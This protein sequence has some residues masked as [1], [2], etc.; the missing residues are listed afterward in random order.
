MDAKE[1]Y[2]LITRNLQEIVGHD[3][4][5]QILEERDL[6]VYWGTATTG[7]PHIGYFVPIVKI[8]DFLKAGCSVKLLFADLHA[9]LDNQKAP[10][11]LLEHRT[12]YYKF[13]IKEMLMSIGVPIEKLKFVKGTDHQLGNEYSLDMY[14]LATLASLR[15]TKKA[16][17]EVVKQLENPKM[18]PLLYPIL[19]ALD[20]QY[21]GVDAQFGGVDQ[22]KIFM[23]AREFLPKIEYPKR[24]HLMNPMMPGLTGEKMSSSVE[25]TKIDLLD[26]EKTV[27]KKI[28]KAFCPEG[29]VEDNGVL[30]FLKNVTFQILDNKSEKFVIERDEKYGGNLEF[31][32]YEELERLYAKKE[33]HPADLKNA[34]ARE[35][36]KVLE[37]I[38]N[39]FNSDK[40]IQFTYKQAYP[41]K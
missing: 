25:S 21:L 18:G 39:K 41:K 10:W 2:D 16:G 15:D 5:K 34:M 7:R 8:A 38:R 32:T 23:F 27:T 36:N 22:R 24:I 14:R 1:K 13:L 20:E 30:M 37:P 12:D 31:S 4:L 3:E 35:L 40:K 28:N 17:A 19:Q 9:Y 6:N 26:D 33:I 29:K 11:N